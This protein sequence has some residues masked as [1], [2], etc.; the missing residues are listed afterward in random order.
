[1]NKIRIL[2]EHT[3]P[4]ILIVTPLLPDHKVSKLTKKT[5]KRNNV[6]Y[7]WITSEGNNNIPTNAL[8]GIKWWKYKG[9]KEETPLPPYYIMID[10][11]IEMGRGMLDRL[12]SKLSKTTD[13][14]GY[15]Y[16]TFQFKGHINAD[17]PAMPFDI[18]KLV[19]S[20]YIS[21]NSLFKSSVIEQVG[22]VTDNKYK[23]LLDYAFLLKCF[24]MGYV[25]V[26]EP[27]SWFIAHSTEDDISA[28][29]QNEYREKY[30]KVYRDFIEPIIKN[31]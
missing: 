12:Y 20:N 18:N 28:G 13:S 27:K 24:K 14:V 26:P 8:E 6:P 4:E 31:T 19:Q 16:S 25:G 5:L 30:L 17:F 7:T 29:S 1:M 23:R 15:C 11:D 2:T 9:W 21:S 10:R 3:N 22:L